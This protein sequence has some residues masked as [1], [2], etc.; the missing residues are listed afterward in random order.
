LQQN[1]KKVEAEDKNCHAKTML[2]LEKPIKLI[3][4]TPHMCRVGKSTR[5]KYE[6]R[7]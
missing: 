4:K 5:N 7:S 3:W 2:S 1:K 6:G